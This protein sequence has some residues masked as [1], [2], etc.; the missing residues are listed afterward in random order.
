MSR[1]LQY[2]CWDTIFPRDVLMTGH[3]ISMPWPWNRDQKW[4]VICFAMSSCETLLKFS[5][6]CTMSHGFWEFKTSS[7]LDVC[8]SVWVCVCVCVC[9]SLRL[10][11][12]P[13]QAQCQWSQSQQE[14]QFQL[15][16]CQRFF[17]SIEH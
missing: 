15:H 16:G 10:A 12:R 13:Y 2:S 14:S 5:P 3:C 17:F 9:L 7:S 1:N 4:D 11:V 8:A 6:T